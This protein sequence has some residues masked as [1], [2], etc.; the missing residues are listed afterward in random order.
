[1]ADTAFQIQYRQEF[2]H[3]FEDRQSVL[4]STC[5]QESVIKGNRAT[6]LVADSGSA[7]AVNRGVQGMITAR[8]DNLTQTTAT[9]LEWHD[10][11]RRTNFNIFASQG[12]ARRIMQ[13]T[14]MAVV[15]RKIDDIIIAQ[16]DT[17]TNDA[18][19]TAAV[20]SLD[21]VIKAQTILGNNFVD[22]SD[23]DNL[24]MLVTPAFRG[25]MMQNT[26]F[27]SGDYVD[28]KPFSGPA[29]RFWRWNGFNWIV[30]PRLTNSIGAGGTSASEQCYAYHRNALGCAVDKDG[31]DSPVG[32]DVEQGYSFARVSVHMGAALL[33]NSGVCQLLHNGSAYAAS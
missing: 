33:Q 31:I 27:A 30:H 20:A 11:V 6:F 14:T 12:D 25:Y 32:Y 19:T 22:L 1:M 28:V 2:I 5:V 8:A 4:R 18:G 23:E 21:M 15:N 7:T 17:A 13:E 29:R 24:F 3:G 26:E 10:L 16:L 9:L